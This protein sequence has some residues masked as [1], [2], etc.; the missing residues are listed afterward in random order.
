VES[1]EAAIVGRLGPAP[2]PVDELIRQCSFSAPVIR[3]VLL[4]LELAG[5][6][7]RHPGDAVSMLPA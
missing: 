4:E 6:L 7:E 3:T 5:R 2:V 1:A